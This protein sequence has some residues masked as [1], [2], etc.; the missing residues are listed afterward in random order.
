MKKRD[1]LII[2]GILVFAGLL[3]LIINLTKKPGAGVIVRIN[4]IEVA[5]Y[6]FDN[7]GTYEL[8]G[9]TNILIIKDNE[10]W[11][12]SATCKDKICVKEGK[13]SKE[14]ETITCLPNKLT[15]TVY[16]RDSFVEIEWNQ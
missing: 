14:G 8:N 1:I 3:L 16:G 5:K 4:G 12:E 2:C 11:L 13:I 9:G 15:V 6:S 10:A 7:E